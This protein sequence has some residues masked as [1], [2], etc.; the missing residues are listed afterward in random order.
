MQGAPLRMSAPGPATYQARPVEESG[1]NARTGLVAAALLLVL[2]A[3][4]AGTHEALADL[5]A[6]RLV[7]DRNGLTL[8]GV[9]SGAAM[10]VQY[11]VAHSATVAGVGSIAGPGWGC[12][13][14]S[15][16]TAID[17]CMCGRGELSSMH[18]T[19]RKL[20]QNPNGGLDRL[21]PDPTQAA[22]LL[23]RSLRR[24]YVF[25]SRADETMTAAPQEQ[26]IE[27][28]RAYTGQEPVVDRGTPADKSDRAGHGI[29]SPDG[30]DSCAS[31]QADKTY[32][33][34][35][36]RHDNVASLF[37]ALY[38]APPD[39]ISAQQPV[40]TDKGIIAFRQTPFIDAVAATRPAIQLAPDG[41]MPF[42]RFS[43]RRQKFDLADTGYLFVPE[44][45]RRANVNCKVHVALHGCKQ[46]AE[47][48]ARHAG[49]N[50]WAQ[51][52]NVI[53]VYPA[54]G[55]Y[56]PAAASTGSLCH[57]SQAW[58][59][60]GWSLFAAYAPKVN[61]NGCWDWW[62]YLDDTADRGRYLTQRSPQ[63]RFI[64]LLVDAL[65]NPQI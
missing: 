48:F 24:S 59:S 8:S 11:A 45:C 49:Y 28:L 9:S 21:E 16:Q 7:A 37:R 22:R 1:M 50:R 42:W 23:P 29:L 41:I 39:D 10:A 65:T 46:N 15:V 12:A 38:G 36:D 26:A 17:T 60:W 4:E 54:I 32:I 64:K 13:Q 62:G 63:I 61:Y 40:Q 27:F 53:V 56:Q 19:A 25:H 51:R 14:G 18:A 55:A 2:P 5:R 33:R 3:C 34:N 31:S 43:A 6:L 44:Q 52:Y 47:Y 20:A 57:K 30:S 35:C 58:Q